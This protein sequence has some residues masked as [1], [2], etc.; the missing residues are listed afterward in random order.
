MFL[1]TSKN[2]SVH[3]A[4]KRFAHKAKPSYKTDSHI[5]KFFN[6]SKSGIVSKNN[7]TKTLLQR[8]EIYFFNPAMGRKCI[9]MFTN[10]CI[11]LL[12]ICN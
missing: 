3:T 9:E 2:I 11:R 12:F 8:E 7:F 6:V 4:T 1:Q 5:K 10:A